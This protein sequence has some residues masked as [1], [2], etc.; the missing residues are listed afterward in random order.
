MITDDSKTTKRGLRIK[1]RYS[2]GWADAI[3]QARYT[4]PPDEATVADFRAAL[5]R[6]KPGWKWEIRFS[7][8]HNPHGW[9]EPNDWELRADARRL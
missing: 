1:L 8:P 5:P 4:N 9:G 3:A 6:V 2:L 7:R